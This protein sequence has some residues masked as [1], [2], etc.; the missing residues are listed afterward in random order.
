MKIKSCTF[1][2]TSSNAPNAFVPDDEDIEVAWWSWRLMGTAS[3]MHAG[4]GSGQAMS[5]LSA[6]FRICRALST[7][8][9]LRAQLTAVAM[10][11]DTLVLAQRVVLMLPDDYSPGRGWNGLAAGLERARGDFGQRVAASG[12][13]LRAEYRDALLEE[14]RGH[15]AWRQIALYHVADSEKQRRGME[16]E[17]EVL[18]QEFN[19]EKAILECFAAGLQMERSVLEGGRYGEP[20]AGGYGVSVSTPDE[21]TITLTSVDGKE[22][23]LVRRRAKAQEE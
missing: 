22:C 17:E 6:A 3:L 2:L 15:G 9:S 5:D 8:G 4:N 10:L 14:A 12:S 20:A 21:H 11:T 23:W 1:C 18:K 16:V 13:L 7:S 19:R